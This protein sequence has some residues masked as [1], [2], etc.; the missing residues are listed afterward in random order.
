MN[1]NNVN[2][3]FDKISI[4]EN[5]HKIIDTENDKEIYLYKIHN[6]NIDSLNKINLLE[7]KTPIEKST[8]SQEKNEYL[9][10][11]NLETPKLDV[12]KKD[13]YLNFKKAKFFRNKDSPIL[14][15]DRSNL[16]KRI[17]TTLFSN[18]RN[19]PI[20]SLSPIHL[21][22]IANVQYLNLPNHLNKKD[23]FPNKPFEGE[24]KINS[25]NMLKLKIPNHL[26]NK[27]NQADKLL[28]QNTNCNK[29]NSNKEIINL[30]FVNILNSKNPIL[31]LGKFDKEILSK[32]Q[33]LNYA[34]NSVNNI[35]YNQLKR[36]STLNLDSENNNI[37]N[38]IKCMKDQIIEKNYF[39]E[40]STEQPEIYCVAEYS[41]KDEMNPRYRNYM[42]DF[43]K[44]I[45]KFNNNPKMGFF[46]IFDGHG[47]EDSAKYAKE[48]IPELLAKNLITTSSATIEKCIINSFIQVDNELKFY[49]SENTGTTA[50]V[51]LIYERNLYLANVGDSKCVM[52]SDN[53]IKT[54][55]YDHK[56]TDEKEIERVKKSKGKIINNRINGQ[57]ALSRALG[58]YS[59][60]RYGVISTPFTN[61]VEIEVKDKFI[62]IASDGVWDVTDEN[63]INLI[64]NKSSLPYEI[65]EFIIQHS[66][67]KGSR[68]NISCIVIKLI[69]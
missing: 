56:C 33:N 12:K 64:V 66:I 20:L 63:D 6:Q 17:E 44:I 62:I 2:S 11:T 16:K 19:S 68:D 43:I 21:H 29:Y 55:S 8:N 7:K 59:L 26:I 65:C 52:V 24:N 15:S 69:S 1:N 46:S 31:N 37:I 38:K 42:E 54:L 13:E 5:F 30:N 36:K 18:L 32:N 48:R 57:L 10:N 3:S 4:D 28:Y 50:T 34:N 40:N 9:D 67:L 60:K 58:D 14:N 35:N 61:K 51:I 49:D 41:N 23:F 53:E 47:G 39:Q 25:L 22:N 27:S 45:D